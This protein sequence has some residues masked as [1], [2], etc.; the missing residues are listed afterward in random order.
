MT[1]WINTSTILVLSEAL[2]SNLQ[3]PQLIQP[4]QM[5]FFNSLIAFIT[6]P[7]TLKQ[8]VFAQVELSY[9][10]TVNITNRELCYIV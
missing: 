6:N 8:G 7:H 3:T 2:L 1:I 9:I 10:I 4:K 5:H